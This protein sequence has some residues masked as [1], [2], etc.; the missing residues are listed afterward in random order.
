MSRQPSVKIASN[1]SFFS[2]NLIGTNNL[3]IFSPLS[4]QIVSIVDFKEFSLLLFCL[5]IWYKFLVE[6]AEN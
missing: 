6:K 1:F 2:N 5:L 4:Q 3:V